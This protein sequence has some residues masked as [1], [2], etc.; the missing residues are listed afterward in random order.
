V[1]FRRLEVRAYRAIDHAELEFGPGLNVLYGPND[2]GKSTLA[3]AMRAA[4]LLPAESTAHQSFLPWHG[5][6]PPKVRLTFERDGITY[7]VTKIF[8]SGSLGSAQLE[9]SADGSSFQ[10]EERG[11]A[12][13]RR[14][15]ELLRWGIEAPGGKGGARGLP[16]SFL[17][18]VLLGNQSDVPLIL[19]RSLQADRDGSG[20]ERLHE[21]LQALS[22]D[23][24]FKR[25]LEAAQ[26][27]VDAAFTPTG[28]R[29]TGQSSPFAPLKEQITTLAQELE[30]LT[31]QRRESEDVQQ[32]LSSLNEARSQCE[33]QRRVLE[34]QIE[35][36]AE[37]IARLARREQAVAR[38]ARA[39]Q[40]HAERRAERAELEALEA[41]L[42]A[43]Q[44][45]AEAGQGDIAA[46]AARRAEMEQLAAAAEQRAAESTS[47]SA[48]ADRARRRVEL[49]AL[50]RQKG[51]EREAMLRLLG[52]S[53]ELEAAEAALAAGG[54]ALSAAESAE[55]AA[56]R[57]LAA[58]DAELAELRELEAVASWQEAALGAE[59][60][61]AALA[62]A[63]KLL[64]EAEALRARAAAEPVSEALAAVSPGVLAGLRTLHDQIR[65]AAARLDV[66]LSLTL[67]VPVGQVLRARLDGG[68]E[69]R[70]DTSGPAIV[71]HAKSRITATLAGGVELEA[72]AGDPRER[73]QLAALERRWANE[74]LP[75]FRDCGV[76]DLEA[77]GTQLQAAQA[78]QRQ[79]AEWLRE[80]ASATA[81]A[82][83]KGELAGDLE[84]LEQRVAQR[85]QALA[86]LDTGELEARLA[87]ARQR[88]APGAR[89]P[90]KARS[91]EP[92]LERRRARAA[93]ERER[94]DAELQS[95]IAARVGGLA[96][97]QGLAEARDALLARRAE[98]WASLAGAGP[99]PERAELRERH[100]ALVAASDAAVA[101]LEGWQREQ[102]R[103][104]AAARRERDEAARAL[105]MARDRHDQAQARNR[106]LRER[107]LT[108]E[109]QVKE[110]RS[111]FDPAAGVAAQRELEAARAEL[112]AFGAVEAVTAE[113]HAAS[114]SELERVCSELER[115]LAEL[116]RAEGALGHVGGDVVTMRQQQTEEALERARVLELDQEREYDAYRLLLETLRSVENEEGVH[117]GKALEAPVS[118][119]FERLTEGRYRQVGLDGGLSLAG[120]AVAG[121]PRAYGELSEGTQEQLA[122]ILRLCIAEYLQT[123]LVLD[124]H[125]AQ[126]H[127]RR[128]EWFRTTLREAAERIQIVVLT[129]RPED[130]LDADELG[131][132]AIVRDTPGQ[133]VRAADL[134]RIISRAQYGVLH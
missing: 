64:G 108:L 30:R 31:H 96:R 49:E 88:V 46:A 60:A 43:A 106:E 104:A 132:A 102:D 57:E 19:E 77:L 12:V 122:T 35:R 111:R 66:G 119:R 71:Q 112:D 9:S 90:E 36:E 91:T 133:R 7:R 81:R 100:A 73:E 82:A 20:R 70:L 75:L 2:L 62:D 79:A 74:A 56:R 32:R 127:R 78:R 21:A 72:T 105:A 99:L 29:K 95:Q 25:V 58:V 121:R 13:D 16:E 84:Q 69:Q 6:G 34:Q 93:G 123:A 54:K 63:G 17:S 117:L 107:V 94:L 8:G 130:Y 65:I 131:G 39:E 134:E 48:L 76:E 92:T 55:A 33:A 18:H 126:T 4:L 114:R 89:P 116:R 38:L 26:A 129:A 109:A 45:Q 124:D 83:E 103:S 41:A 10:E 24:V 27:K 120:V 59:R 115:T 113:R 68:A 42:A 40:A 1:R 110:R 87:A 80:A 125:L 118:E 50:A 98:A 23:P 28:R 37:L 85:R 67:R 44:A 14:L 128:A 97:K 86:H 51:A 3:S 53:S 11:R 47:E 22:Q 101:E 15:R 5:V 61:R 52:L